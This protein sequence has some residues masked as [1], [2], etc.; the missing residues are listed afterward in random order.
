MDIKKKKTGICPIPIA[1]IILRIP[2][3][4]RFS[5]HWNRLIFDPKMAK[6]KS[7][8][9]RIEV[10]IELQNLPNSQNAIFDGYRWFFE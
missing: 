6:P 2:E 8:D 4:G 1:S 5:T 7:K 10:V 3:S 9:D